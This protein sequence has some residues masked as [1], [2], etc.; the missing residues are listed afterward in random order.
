MYRANCSVLH[1][2]LNCE[3]WS[4]CSLLFFRLLWFGNFVRFGFCVFSFFM[5]FDDCFLLFYTLVSFLVLCVV[6]VLNFGKF[7]RHVF[8]GE[9]NEKLRYC[10]I[11]VSGLEI[12]N[13]KSRRI[14]ALAFGVRLAIICIFSSPVRY[15][16]WSSSMPTIGKCSLRSEDNR[17][18]YIILSSSA[19]NL[20]SVISALIICS[21]VSFTV[22]SWAISLLRMSFSLTSEFQ[23]AVRYS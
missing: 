6:C 1:M 11:A 4:G 20:L 3:L 5:L 23:S 21:L 10:I 19:P 17:K 2:K 7:F 16:V 14:T 8:L 12:L 9:L 15:G 22:F 18:K 13:Q